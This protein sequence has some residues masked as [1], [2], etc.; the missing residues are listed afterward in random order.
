MRIETKDLILKKAVQDDWKE[1]YHNLWCHEESARY[2]L[3]T[4]T[5]SEEEA[6]DRMRRTIE[7]EKKEK[8]ALLVYEKNTGR[9]IGFAG[10]REIEPGVFEETGV[11]LGPEFVGKGY[12]KQV[13]NALTQEA[14]EQCGAKKFLACCRTENIASHNLQKSCGF[15]LRYFEKKIDSRN[16]RGFIMEYNEK[17]AP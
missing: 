4:V 7:F 6:Q 9:A 12:G 17:T 2:M 5:T 1:M 14:F 11:A 3:W 16:G 15:K 10:M 13:L 8:Y